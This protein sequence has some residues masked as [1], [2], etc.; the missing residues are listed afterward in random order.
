[1]STKKIVDFS[2]FTFS[3]SSI[4]DVMKFCYSSLG[5]LDKITPNYSVFF[6]ARNS[7]K[8]EGTKKSNIVFKFYKA[9][10]LK[11]WQIPFTFNKY[12][13]SLEP[14]FVLVH[15]FGYAHYLIFLKIMLSKTKIILQSNGYARKPDGLK[16]YIYKISDFFIDAY[17]FT[18]IENA[19]PWYENRILRKEKVFSIME[20]STNFKFS[21]NNRRR[22]N[23]F[24][25]VGRLDKNKDPITILNAFRNFIKVENNAKLTM[26]FHENDLLSEVENIVETNSKLKKAV[27]LKGYVEHHLLENIY[28]QY[29]FFI[30]GSHYEGS[31]YALVEAMACG[32][33]PVITD[34][35][36]FKFMTNNGKCAFLFP[37]SNEKALLKQLTSTQEVNT[38]ELQEKV[39]DQFNSKLSF[40]AIAKDLEYVLAK[41]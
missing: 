8:I 22:S 23:S 35:P 25:W 27:T 14:D 30:L 32:C 21:G 40:E 18:G 4:D 12:I 2:Y 36:P 5:Y 38:S 1:M 9:T 10:S 24:L 15:G 19:L 28:H 20:G 26:I 41:V 6:V 31:G 11:K 7:K 29:Q 3:S 13:K 34:I 37:P 17:L 33:I 16:K 39:L